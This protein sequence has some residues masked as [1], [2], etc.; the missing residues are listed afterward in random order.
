MISLFKILNDQIKDPKSS[1]MSFKILYDSHHQILICE[2]STNRQLIDDMKLCIDT[3]IKL[4]SKQRKFNCFILWIMPFVYKMT[5]IKCIS[6]SEK[7]DMQG[8]YNFIVYRIE[9]INEYFLNNYRMSHPL[10]LNDSEPKIKSIH[11]KIDSLPNDILC[12]I[13][14][15]IDSLQIL[16]VSKKIYNVMLNCEHRCLKGCCNNIKWSRQ[17]IYNKFCITMSAC[18]TR[19]TCRLC[20]DDITDIIKY[21]VCKCK[22]ILFYGHIC[23][24]DIHNTYTTKTNM[25]N[26]ACI[27][28][29][30]K[31]DMCF[32]CT[33]NKRSRKHRNTKNKC[34]MSIV[35]RY[36][37]PT[38]VMH[39]IMDQYT[40]IDYPDKWLFVQE[41]IE[42]YKK[43]CNDFIY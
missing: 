2:C 16:C 33:R 34:I 42:N 10:L 28:T 32:I 35:N 13:G 19:L 18:Q 22:K 3:K 7:Y 15:Y 21:V 23:D 43:G 5:T 40:D 12:I 11:T 38:H 9:N 26:H 25:L 6:Y 31:C 36:Y 8:N 39:N 17:M 41:D 20:D 1:L 4:N 24:R 27:Y 37:V 14:N 30:Q 29:K